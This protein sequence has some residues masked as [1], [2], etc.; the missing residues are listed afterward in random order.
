M[1]TYLLDLAQR[2]LAA[3]LLTLAGLATAA[4]PF[5]M[6]AFQWG[7]AL[8]TAGSAAVLTLIVGLAARFSRDKNSA[9]F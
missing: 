4:E 1:R 6:L 2:V 8:A 3:F 5:D 9:G 7:T